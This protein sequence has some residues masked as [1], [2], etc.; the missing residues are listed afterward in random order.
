MELSIHQARKLKTTSINILSGFGLGL[1]YVMLSDGLG[2]SFPIINGVTI[3]VLVGLVVSLLEL[4]VFTGSIRKLRFS[5]IILI[6]TTLYLILITMIILLELMVARMVKYNLGFKE[7]WVSREFQNY[8]FHMDFP[9]VIIYTLAIAFTVNF[10]RQMNRKMGQ[11][12]LWSFITGKY[13]KPTQTE[14]IFMF[15]RLKNSSQLVMKLGRLEFHKFLNDFAFD[16]TESILIH[17]GQ[18][19]QYIEDE[20]VV[21]WNMDYGLKDANC[22]RTFFAIKKSL[23]ELREQYFL[24]FGLTPKFEAAFHCG[25]VIQGEIGAVK[26]EIAF[27]GDVMNTSSRILGRCSELSKDLLLSAHLMYRLDLPAIYKPEVCGKILL[28]GKEQPMELFS[29]KESIIPSSL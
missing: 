8:L 16:I 18:I 17:R 29:I 5:Y 4:Q 15:M 28:K 22:I 13:Y 12:V 14:R 9:V 27:L 6:R 1:V 26:S 2:D 7:V 25:P 20:I 11:G 10:T 3:G 24:K 23:F 21:V 19:Y